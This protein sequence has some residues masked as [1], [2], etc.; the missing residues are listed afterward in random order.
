MPVLE[1]PLPEFKASAFASGLVPLVFAESMSAAA[2]DRWSVIGPGSGGA[3][4]PAIG[5]NNP[6]HVLVVCDM[7]GSY[8][9]ED[10]GASWRVFNLR[11]R[12]SQFVTIPPRRARCTPMESGFTR[13]WAAASAGAWS[14]P[15]REAF[16]QVGQRR[17]SR[18]YSHA[19][20]TQ[21]R[22]AHIGA[23]P[24][25]PTIAFRSLGSSHVS[26]VNAREPHSKPVVDS[27]PDARVKTARPACSWL[28]ASS[29]SF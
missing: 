9:A 2:P 20:C 19:N 15:I 25:V 1:T 16:A 11:E 17:R 21:Y 4:L 5:P 18:L 12:T 22:T 14:V 10:A 6:S 8:L 28:A 27:R 26:A 23:P 29:R 3:H 7:T 13:V 24:R